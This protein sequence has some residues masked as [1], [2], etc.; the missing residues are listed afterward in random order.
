MAVIWR[1]L[2]RLPDRV[3]QDQDGDRRPVG[4]TP[5]E[6]KLSRTFMALAC[7]CA[8]CYT[9]IKW[10]TDLQTASFGEQKYTRSARSATRTR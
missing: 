4:D 1:I 2:G 10:P 9:W 3:L 7:L 6:L 5:F 8:D